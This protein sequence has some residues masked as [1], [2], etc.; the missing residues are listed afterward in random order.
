M[1]FLR[2]KNPVS[3]VQAL[4]K[5]SALRARAKAYG[6]TEKDLEVLGDV[7]RRFGNR[8]LPFP[9]ASVVYDRSY[10]KL[11]NEGLIQLN[12]YSPGYSSYSD[13]FIITAE[14]RRVL[15]GEGMGRRIAGRLG[16]GTSRAMIKRNPVL[17]IQK[18]DQSE[19]LHRANRRSEVRCSVRRRSPGRFAPQSIM[20]DRTVGISNFQGMT[21]ATSTGSRGLTA[22]LSRS[23]RSSS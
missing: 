3:P 15:T 2:Y 12:R 21:V 5:Y 10:A 9:G 22:A 16:P 18:G 6:L 23:S 19:L 7:S 8:K 20:V 11:S 4:D 1:N 17:D 13:H 14:G